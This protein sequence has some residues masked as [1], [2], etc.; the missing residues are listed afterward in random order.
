[1]SADAIAFRALFAPNV[2]TLT[3]DDDV[4]PANAIECDRVCVCVVKHVR[5]YHVRSIR[6]DVVI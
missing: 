2:D 1:M 5:F 6:I 3:H 4:I